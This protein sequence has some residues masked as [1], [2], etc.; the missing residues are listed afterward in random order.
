MENTSLRDTKD[1]PA[2]NELS[3][4]GIYP[5]TAS[6]F[7]AFGVGHSYIFHVDRDA[8]KKMKVNNEART[9]TRAKEYW[10]AIFKDDDR[11]SCEQVDNF[12]KPLGWMVK[13]TVNK[14]NCPELKDTISD[15]ENICEREPFL[16]KLNNIETIFFTTGVAVLVLGV[17]LPAGPDR[18]LKSLKALRDKKE[19]EEL[20]AKAQQIIKK[21]TELYTAFL[22]NA[23]EDKRHFFKKRKRIL[24]RFKEVDRQD[25]DTKD[26]I[27][28]YPLLFVDS[29]TYKERISDI[30]SQVAGSDEQRNRQSDEATVSYEHAEVYVDWNEA[31]VSSYTKDEQRQIE[32]VFLIAMTSWFALVLMSRLSTTYLFEAF[33]GI[34]MKKPQPTANEVHLRNMAYNNVADAALPIRWTDARKDLYL[35]ETIHRNWSSDRWR[36]DIEE[37]MKLLTLHYERLENEQRERLN[38]RLTFVGI[39]LTISTL[40]SAAASVINLAYNDAAEKPVPFWGWSLNKIDIYVSLSIPVLVG[41]LLFLGF[42]LWTKLR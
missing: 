5:P 7:I 35:L 17:E 11:W 4:S 37:R 13:L 2:Q 19:R 10:E 14:A 41:L 39:I 34:V 18:T 38:K 25:L 23:E 30:L 21:C 15:L 28:F 1:H 22:N 8:R 20:K 42:W 31:L 40:A 29:V 16:A 33:V 27:Y 9:K 36:R 3:N 32:T 26:D 24:R 12:G 6:L